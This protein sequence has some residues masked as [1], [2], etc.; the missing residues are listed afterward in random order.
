MKLS[1]RTWERNAGNSEVKL[2]GQT[3]I[4]KKEKEMKAESNCSEKKIRGNRV[5]YE[6]V[7]SFKDIEVLF[8]LNADD[9]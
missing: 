9:Q 3:F 5:Q 7:C 4:L 1:K 6:D 2:K 8:S